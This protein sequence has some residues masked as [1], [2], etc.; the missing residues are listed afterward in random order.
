MSDQTLPLYEKLETLTYRDLRQL[1]RYLAV[2]IED[3]DDASTDTILEAL[4]GAQGGA[5]EQ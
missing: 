2:Y 5:A 1:A 4:E 3:A